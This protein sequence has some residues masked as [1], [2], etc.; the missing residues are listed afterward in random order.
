[1]YLPY[2]R[3]LAATQAQ[4][5]RHGIT[6]MIGYQRVPTGYT[7][8][9]IWERFRTRSVWITYRRMLGKL[10]HCPEPPA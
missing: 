5:R 7:L 3:R 9:A 10:L 8:S 4:L 1:M 2:L 6:P